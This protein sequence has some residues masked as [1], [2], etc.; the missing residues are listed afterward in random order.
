MENKE[1][2]EVFNLWDYHLYGMFNM[3]YVQYMD[4]SPPVKLCCSI[5]V[6]L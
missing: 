4:G 3:W 2:S 1:Y 6:V 5:P